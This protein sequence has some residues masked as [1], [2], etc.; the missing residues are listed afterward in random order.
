MRL[1]SLILVSL[2]NACASPPGNEPAVAPM[3]TSAPAAGPEASTTP[4]A[5]ATAVPTVAPEAAV[6]EPKV[7]EKYALVVSFISP[8]NGTDRDAYDKLMALVKKQTKHLAVVTGRWG[9]EGEHDEC[10]Q[11]SEL[12]DAEK[13]AFVDAVR[14]EM[15]SSKRVNIGENAACNA[16]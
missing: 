12:S 8:G 6:P 2:L 10:F 15:G 3:E 9:K 4:E 1:P 13:T 5:T 7:V 14:K 11:L 16:R